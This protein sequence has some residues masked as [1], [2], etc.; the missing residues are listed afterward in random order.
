MPA[1]FR[2]SCHLSIFTFLAQ[3]IEPRSF[4]VLSNNF[5]FRTD[6]LSQHFNPTNATPPIFQVFN[7][8]F[9]DILGPEASIVEIASNATFAFAHEAPVYV[10]TTDEVFFAS[11]DG[12][13]LGN[14][15]LNHNNMV[16]KLSLADAERALQRSGGRVVDVPI[17]HVR[18]LG[19]L[20]QLR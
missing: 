3:F 14:S 18:L 12:G 17:I 10:P 2:Y 20:F 4:A 1:C 6:S 11:N 7:Q 15:D 16:F 9:L 5:P 13:S 19:Q 8:A